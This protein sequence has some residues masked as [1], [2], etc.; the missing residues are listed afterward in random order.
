MNELTILGVQF[1]SMFIFAIISDAKWGRAKTII[2][3][4]KLLYLINFTL[5]HLGF[6]LYLIGY[7]LMTLITRNQSPVCPINEIIVTNS[8]SIF[9]ERCAPLVLSTIVLT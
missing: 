9:A 1:I 8:S 5:F 7:I 2:I 6:P 3:G 4:K